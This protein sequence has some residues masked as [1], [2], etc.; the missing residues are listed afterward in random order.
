MKIQELIHK[1]TLLT[2]LQGLLLLVI[3]ATLFSVCI[4]LLK[5]GVM[6]DLNAMNEKLAD[7]QTVSTE[8]NDQQTIDG[9]EELK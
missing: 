1:R 9:L 3:L 2:V 6:A 4:G 5:T 7:Q 8:G